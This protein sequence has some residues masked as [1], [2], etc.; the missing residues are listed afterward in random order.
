[1]QGAGK[2]SLLKAILSQGRITT[3][4]NIEHLLPETDAHEGIAGGLCYCDSAGINLQV[5]YPSLNRVNL[6][7][8][9]LLYHT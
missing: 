3:F 6:S 1:M 7:F 2:T 9:C 8:I 4:T 5:T